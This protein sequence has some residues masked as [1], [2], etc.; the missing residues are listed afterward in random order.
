MPALAEITANP[1]ALEDAANNF[2][3][4]R[5]SQ[6][7]S[8]EDTN[9]GIEIETDEQFIALVNKC[10]TNADMDYKKFCEIGEDD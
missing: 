9:K 7:R 1:Q 8:V 4:F 3:A 10:G 6:T 2:A 5:S